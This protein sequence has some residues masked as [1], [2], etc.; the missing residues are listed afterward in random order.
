MLCQLGFELSLAIKLPRPM[1]SGACLATV[2]PLPIPVCGALEPG[3]SLA[4][5]VV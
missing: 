4:I 1:R 2:P 3:A 5:Y